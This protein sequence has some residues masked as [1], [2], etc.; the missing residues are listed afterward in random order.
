[1]ASVAKFW[2]FV[3]INSTGKRQ[4]E[5]VMTAQTY[6]QSAFPEL[7][8][9]VEVPDT[10][11][12]R[13]LWQKM[14]SAKND[15]G[16]LAEI[17]LRCYISHQVHQVCYDLGVQ[18]GSRHGFSCEDLL[19]F[20][21]DDEVLLAEH[22]STKVQ[23]SSS[24]SSVA[25]KSL[26]T[27]VLQ[28]FDPAKGSLKTW[29]SRYV[30]QHPELKRFLLQCG[31]YLVSDWALLNNTNPKELQ[32]ILTRTY[33]LTSV[34]IQQTCEL[35]VSYHAVYREDRLKQRLTGTT[36]PCQPPNSEQLTRIANELEALTGQRLSSKIILNQLQ[37]VATKLR[38][39]RIAAQGG[40][41]SSV[42]LDEP[43]IQ[44]IVERSPTTQ[45]DEEQLEF[46]Q[47]YQNQFLQCLD[48]SLSQVIDDALANL[49]RKRSPS[50]EI[51]K[52]FLTGL[53]LLHCQGQSM[54]QIAPQIGLKKQYE[55]TRLL[56]LNELRTDIRQ[57][58]LVLLRSCVLE[59]AKLFAD[60]E[61]LQSLDKQVELI[62]D[63]QI[64]GIIQE[65]ESEVRNPV[66]NKPLRSLLARR[67]CLY[68]N[69]RNNRL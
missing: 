67:I 68:L 64:S 27:T 14:R 12:A 31:V 26:A 6:L 19:A 8:Q 65:A 46:I 17:C 11:L 42:S 9:Q 4:V 41:I 48:N 69:S 37:A 5:M 38:R 24:Q 57:R 51:E 23:K 2:E 53:H 32:R 30:K 29:V 45:D 7:A 52:I 21:L 58:L 16:R 20:V 22:N 15:D 50:K 35:L 33:N 56:K 66:R 36:L 47:L 55:V 34:E 54:P 44:P 3:K 59:S 60:P 43:E 10:T 63:E 61:R 49:S 1:V 18:F 39:Y 40:S 13:E 25:Y 28:T 62:L